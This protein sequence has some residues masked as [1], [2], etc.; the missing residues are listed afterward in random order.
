MRCAGF[1]GLPKKS[2]AYRK[3]G[4]VIAPFDALPSST[5]ESDRTKLRAASESLLHSE[6]SK[7][8]VR[9]FKMSLE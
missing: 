9:G 4:M 1:T 3:S 6:E 2:R 7:N 8:F 5:R